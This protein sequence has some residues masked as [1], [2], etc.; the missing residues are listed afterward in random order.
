MSRESRLDINTPQDN[1]SIDLSK[2]MGRGPK[3]FDGDAGEFIR[4]LRNND[5][6]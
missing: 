1:K 3:M 6:I 4:E 2:Y 5:R